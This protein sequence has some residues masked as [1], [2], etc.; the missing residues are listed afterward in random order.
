MGSITSLE[1]YAKE[2]HVPIIQKD[3][4]NFLIKYIKENNIKNILEIGSAIG[5]SAINMAL[6]DKS[7]KI[8]TIERNKEMF[9]LAQKNIKDFNLENR[10]KVI[11]GNALETEIK[12]KYDLIFIDAAKAQYIKFFE[13]YKFNLKENGTIITDNLNF[14]GLA[15]NVE[16]IHSKNLKALVRKINNYKQFLKENKEFKTIFYENGD[17]I[18]VSKINKSIKVSKLN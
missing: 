16:E 3:G 12:E 1:N 13:K 11:Y 14:H 18:S 5:Y 7:I 9:L 2:N 15:N 8:T 17:G 4:L 6:V 10:I